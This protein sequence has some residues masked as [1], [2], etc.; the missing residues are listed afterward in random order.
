MEGVPKY[1]TLGGSNDPPRV[2]AK[3]WF[4]LFLGLALIILFMYV[5]GPLEGVFP[6]MRSMSSFI[7]RRGL[8]A[9]ALYYTDID[10]FGEATASLNDTLRYT[11][12]ISPEQSRKIPAFGVDSWRPR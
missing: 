1:H 11:P 7:E 12:Q 10:E 6:G 2:G 5:M 8:K 3:Q 4:R 9:T